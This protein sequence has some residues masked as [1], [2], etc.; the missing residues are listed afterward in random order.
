MRGIVT[1]IV[2][3]LGLLVAFG[4]PSSSQAA[5]RSSRLT[6]IVVQDMHCAACAKKIA[7]KLYA[8]QGVQEVRANVQK[9]STYIAPR[10]QTTPSPRKMWEA[11]ESAGF[12]PVKLVGPAGVFTSKPGS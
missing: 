5:E 6:L 4:A 7:T 1:G 3:T 8:V 11:V 9:N 12:K 10:P 2:I